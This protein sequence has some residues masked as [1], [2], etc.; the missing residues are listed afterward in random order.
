MLGCA[1]RRWRIGGTCLI[2]L[3]KEYLLSGITLAG[4]FLKIIN[5]LILERH[6][7][8]MRVRLD[9]IALA[10]D[11]ST[12]PINDRHAIAGFDISTYYA[13]L[14]PTPHIRPPGPGGISSEFFA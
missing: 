8:K 5:D 3:T 9:Q 2:S 10:W 6:R 1:I 13:D 4:D 7:N 12:F 11:E 14:K